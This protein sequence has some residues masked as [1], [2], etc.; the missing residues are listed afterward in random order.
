MKQWNSETVKERKKEKKKDN[1]DLTEIERL[2]NK[3]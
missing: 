3:I 1:G 2:L